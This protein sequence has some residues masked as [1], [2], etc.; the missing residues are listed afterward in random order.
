MAELVHED[1]DAEVFSVGFGKEIAGW[2]DSRGT[3]WRIGILPLG[4]YVKFLGD[5]DGASRADPEA[6]AAMSE[7]ERARSFHDASVGRRAATVVA[8][9][10]ANFLLSILVFAGLAIAVGVGSD[11]AVIGEVPESVRGSLP[12]EEGDRVLSVNG[13][14]VESWIAFREAVAEPEEG[15]EITLLIERD[16]VTTT[17]ASPHFMR[18]YVLGIRPLSAASGAGILPGDLI[19]AVDGD[20][21]TTVD[22]L[23]DLIA[24]REGREVT[25]SVHRGEEDLDF[26][27][28]PEM[29]DVQ[30]PDGGFEKRPII[31]VSIGS[32]LAPATE[33]PDPA[34]AVWFGVQRTVGIITGTVNGVYHMIAGEVSASNLQ[35]PLGI[36]QVSGE[37]ARVG[38]QNLIVL[39]AT[40]STAIGFLNLLPIPVLDGGHLVIYAIEAVR[41]R[42][43]GERWIEAAMSVGLALVLLLMVFA[44]YND[45]A[46]LF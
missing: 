23:P 9:P 2:T 24:A 31:G 19:V 27:V 32:V 36:A 16:G 12:V 34:T 35:G 3:R 44:T 37:S 11:E 43:P 18:P 38:L 10:V 42:Q 25:V 20:P 26:R 17:V 15:S 21:V 4:G 5:A 46:R 41:G 33:T 30:T 14:E 7:A 8:G 29:S 39:V 13:T 45:L 22:A 40:I 6:L 28:V 1:D